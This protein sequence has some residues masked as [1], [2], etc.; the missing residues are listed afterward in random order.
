M[1]LSL[2]ASLFPELVITQGI[3]DDTYH[4]LLLA[5]ASTTE[6]ICPN[7]QQRTTHIHSRYERTLHDLPIGKLIVQLRISVRRFFCRNTNCSRKIFAERFPGLTQC[8]AR[9]TVRL[10]QAQGSIALALGGEAGARLLDQLFMPSSPDTMLRLIRHIQTPVSAT[11]RVL[12][13]DDWSF[14][15][16]KRYGTI[17]VDL[18]QHHVIDLLPDRSSQTFATWLRTHPGIEIISRDRAGEYAQ[19][20]Q[21]GAPDAIQVADRFH[22]VQNLS[23]VL[24]RILRRHQAE[25]KHIPVPVERVL[26]Q[27]ITP[28]RRRPHRERVKVAT[29][30]RRL[31]CY[32]E[33]RQ[34][35]LQGQ[36][37]TAIADRLQ[38]SRTK[39]AL[40]AYAEAYPERPPYRAR[41]SMLAPYETYLRERW[42]RGFHNGVGLW[43]EIIAQ[44]YTGS[45]S[46]VAHYVAELRE[47]GLTS[48]EILQPTGGGLTPRQAKM[49][50]IRRK[51]D[52]KERE[53]QARQRIRHIHP[54]VECAVDLVEQFL[55]MMRQR[56]A[57][58]LE[59]WFTC[60]ANSSIPEFKQFVEKLQKDKQAVTNGFQLPWSQGQVEG[61]VN[62][63]KLLKRSMYGRAR[64]DLLRQRV[65]LSSH[66]KCG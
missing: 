19:G 5:H 40:F 64:F 21:Q 54:E 1:N 13:V 20:V 61:Q 23:D 63:L 60:A 25:L 18:E 12:G 30:E 42:V 48:E 22:L 39:A 15:R 9:R 4:L 10:S 46:L 14:H 51:E 56:T 6:G 24:E 2:F 37:I 7:C 53:Q 57:D 62:R 32:Q 65:L 28:A 49:L 36:T 55:D 3:T 17:L 44:G 52:V 35:Y 43:R 16:N 31:A 27:G 29:R 58:P 33:A 11:P 38:I 26:Q 59:E 8:Y 34:L 45:R 47:K 50:C 41:V 66:R